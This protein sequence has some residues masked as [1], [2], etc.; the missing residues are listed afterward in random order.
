MKLLLMMNSVRN[1]Y[2]GY[3]FFFFFFFFLFLSFSLSL[4]LSFSLPLFTTTTTTTTTTKLFPH[5]PS[6]IFISLCVDLFEGT[7]AVEGVL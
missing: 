4:S 7:V 5:P 6:Q 2:F 3:V 1:K